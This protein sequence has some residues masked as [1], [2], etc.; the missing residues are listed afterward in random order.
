M[1]GVYQGGAGG[2]GDWRPN[3]CWS[4]WC[5]GLQG[6]S[7]VY[8]KL[9]CTYIYIYFL[10]L[11]LEIFDQFYLWTNIF[12]SFNFQGCKKLGF[13]REIHVPDPTAQS[14]FSCQGVGDDNWAT[15]AVF[16]QEE[17]LLHQLLWGIR[18]L[19]I[20]WSSFKKVQV[21]WLLSLRGLSDFLSCSYENILFKMCSKT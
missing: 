8:S 5:W 12:F 2:S 3:A 13:A 7:G 4:T 15:Q 18:F 9:M 17:D 14:T 16:A 21:W 10:L 19:D 1:C 20:R 6:L 11:L